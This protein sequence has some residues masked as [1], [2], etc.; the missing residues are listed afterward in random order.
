MKSLDAKL[1]EIKANPSSKSFILADAKDADMA[2]GVR[3]PGP[4]TY[5]SGRGARPAQFSPEVWTRGEFG[6]RNLPEFLDIIRE[7]TRQGKVD[8]MLMSA[9]VSEQL[10]IKEGLFRDSPVT[11]AARA[12]DTTD[13]WAV[14]HGC[15]T[16]EPSQPFRSASIDQI[17]CGEVKCYRDGSGD[18]PGANL[19]LYSI[20]FVNDLDQDREALLWYKAF[21][22]EAERKGFRHFLEVFDPNVDSGV[23]SEKLGEFINDNILRIL[24]GVPEAGRPD[25]LKIVYHGPKA[26]EELAQYDPNL[27]VGILGGGAGTTFDAFRL[28]H[29]AQKYG[30]RVALFGRK[31]NQAEHQLAFIEMLRLIT[32]GQVGPSE[33]VRVYHGVLQSLG[34]RPHRPLDQDL[35]LTDQA[36]SYDGNASKRANATIVNNPLAARQTGNASDT[37]ESAPRLRETPGAQPAESPR[38]GSSHPVSGGKSAE[39]G[40]DRDWPKRAD[41][42]P[43]FA[44]MTPAQRVNYDEARLKRIFG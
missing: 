29:D 11:P 22:E 43:D 30:A 14:R 7:I 38:A 8:I 41:G 39:I 2:F 31:I 28:I 21:R 4:R 16:R 27:V 15:Y 24:A 5:L 9:Y 18:F 40:S 1:A 34:I 23:P 20:T 6:Y 3:A 42:K 26:M 25:F 35:Q 37:S 19:G 12:N 33:A 32:D 36:M 44:R 13:V 10:A 17:Q